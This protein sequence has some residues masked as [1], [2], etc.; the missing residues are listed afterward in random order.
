MTT[1]NVSITPVWSQIADKTDGELLVT[2]KA[3][4]SVEIALTELDAVPTKEGHI[5][6]RET[7]VTRTL[8]GA[9]YVWA[10]IIPG[11]SPKKVVLT[12]SNSPYIS[13]GGG[14]GGSGTDR[15]LVV[16]TYL[17][18]TAFTGASVGDTITAT[19]IIDVTSTPTNVS[20]IW[21]NQTTAANL[22]ST[23]SAVNLELVGSAALTNAQLRAA[24]VSTAPNVSRG[25]GVVDANTQRVTLAS[26]GPGVQNLTDINAKTP[27]LVGGA[28]PVT[29][30]LTD[31]QLRNSPVPVSPQNIT[32]KFRDA[33]EVYSPGQNWNEVK[34]SG[35]LIYVDGNAAAS[36]YLVVSKDP[37]TAGTE[38]TVT[39]ILS[40]DMPIELATGVSMSQR[41]L[42]QE[43]AIEII[44]TQAA[45]AAA[46][47][48]AISSIT[49]ATTVLT[50]DTVTSHGLSVGR[51]FGINGCSNLLAN[52]P[53]LV[54][55]SVPSP[56]QFTATA[57]PGGTIPSQTITNPAGAKGSVYLR[58]RLGRAQNGISQIFESATVTTASLYIRSEAGDAL[59]SGTIAGAHGVT[60]GT[61]A[62]VQLVNS[63]YQYAFIPTSEFR[64]YAQADRVQWADSAI[65]AVTQTTSRLLRTQVCPDPSVGYKVRVRAV[66][67]KA[68]TVPNAQIVTAVK[69]GT[70]TATIT[71]DVAHNLT[72]NDPVAIYGIRDQ[73][74]TSFPNLLTATV[75]ASVVNATTFTIAIGTAGTATSYGGYVAKINGG[76]LP[77][78]LGHS[79]VIAQSATLSTLADGTR[80]L[81]LVG[82]TN[83]AS[84][85]IG[86]LVNTLGVRNAT[87]GAT[88]GV[89]GAWKVANAAT[90]TLTLVLPF[91]GS[92]SLPVDFVST[93]CGG[94]VIKRTDMRLSFVRVFDFERQRVELL[95]RPVGDMAAA[96]PVVM[97]GGS[98]STIATV[99]GVTTVTTVTTV[100]TVTAITTLGT[101]AAPATPFFVNST[102][103]TNG[104]LIL[105]GTSGV[106]AFYASNT[107][108]AAAYVKLYNKATAPTVGTDIP[109]MVVT[110]P[111][112]GQVEL[113]PG[114]NGYRFALGLGIAITAGVA[115]TDTAAVAAGQ[116][117]VKLSRVA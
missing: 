8:L 51:A 31:T 72:A 25:S 75:V 85:S 109:E 44:D 26:D 61:T 15:E 107:G 38:S 7:P 101:P 76:N 20:T 10:K 32:T 5:F 90:T 1:K 37:L 99:T 65:D 66:N 62:P 49:Q 56:T 67:A 117:K 18:K 64:I 43:F 68:L 14:G 53:A 59:P 87:N 102:A 94:G 81:V 113:T 104:A 42:G 48:I 3:A 83:W 77:S 55:A 47:D 23:P 27:A 100:G 58:E 89:D 116:V 29:G 84:L 110:I 21:R 28:V 30:A 114:F 91:T 93:N 13:S 71:T 96:V 35:D 2:W 115:D 57:G 6:A 63:A 80:Q 92:M 88:L 41:T 50:I 34:G 70:T 46:A 105:T 54:V 4:V 33:F 108:A 22:A 16:S 36:S 97:Q 82:N 103:S 78:S 52:Y 12:V 45:L 19:Q 79:A 95:A 111:P 86:D 74:A 40:F 112:N 60:V 73:A 24:A 9:G 69:T 98:L 11:N 106:N 17:C 39:S